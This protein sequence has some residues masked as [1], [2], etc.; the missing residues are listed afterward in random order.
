MDPPG[1]EW[2]DYVHAANELLVVV[3]GTLEMTVAG[4]DFTAHPGDEVFIPKGAA[5]SVKNVHEAET[6][7]LYGYD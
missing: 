2:R 4:R 5:H 6:R 3:D 7:W 1:R